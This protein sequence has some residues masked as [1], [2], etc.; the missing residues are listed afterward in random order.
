MPSFSGAGQHESPGK[1]GLT[2]IAARPWSY[3][4]LGYG[5]GEQ[6]W[7]AFCYRFR[8]AGYDGWSSIEHEDLRLSRREGLTKSVAILK[9][10]AP[11]EASDYAPQE[12]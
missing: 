11:S 1:R 5:Q 9:S 6:W 3:V 7:R 10:V 4:T 2:D 8:I 12:F